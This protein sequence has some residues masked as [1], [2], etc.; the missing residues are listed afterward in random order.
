MDFLD[1]FSPRDRERLLA[2]ASTHRLAR[3]ELLLRRGER[4]GDLYRVHEGELEVV[5][6]R[7]HP[8]IVLDVVGRGGV[9]GEMSFLQDAVRSAD[10]R[11]PDSAVCLRWERGQLVRML[12]QE[13][14]LAAGFYRA[15]AAMLAER[16]KATVISAVAG[17][18]AGAAIPRGPTNEVAAAD[19]RALAE[20]LCG[21]FLELEPVLRRDRAAAER[22][23]GAVLRNFVAALSEA[24]ARMSEDDGAVAGRVIERELHPYTMRS[25]LGELALDRESGMLGVVPLMAHVLAARPGG[26]GPL[27]ELLDGWFLG[28]PTSRGFRE[29]C[30]LATQVVL[31]ALPGEGAVRALIINASGGVVPRLLAQLRGRVQADITCVDGD[32]GALAALDAVVGPRPRDIR[33]RLVQEELSLLC[34]G[35]SGLRF[36]RHPIVVL[37]GVLEYLP[38]RVASSLLRWARGA[39]SP[40]G[41]LVATGLLP[42]PD[43]PVFRHVLAWPLVRRTRPATVRLLQGAGFDV[44]RAYEAGSSGVV[45]AAT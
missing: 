35:R 20:A 29:R 2:A 33:L 21:R 26:D 13:P 1:R 15:L 7:A 40:G 11:A 38:E 37:D 22:E 41:T 42:S 18:L 39:V 4:G 17:G 19:G 32:R 36:A 27:G 6:T 12:E 31:D 14:M 16:S 9:I 10:V 25:H 5:D 34:L 30:E 3:G 44:V 8:A 24:L 43:D 45:V 23:L 28:L